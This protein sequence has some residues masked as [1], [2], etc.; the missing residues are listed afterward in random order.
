MCL[1]LDHTKPESIGI[2]FGTSPDIAACQEL[3]GHKELGCEPESY[4]A[5]AWYILNVFTAIW[6]ALAI[7]SSMISR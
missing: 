4:S 3:S 6:S 2:K 5:I 1:T 7:Q